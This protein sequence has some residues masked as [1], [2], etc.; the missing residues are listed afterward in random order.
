MLNLLTDSSFMTPSS[1]L[2][3]MTSKWVAMRDVAP[4]VSL[5]KYRFHFFKRLSIEYLHRDCLGPL[6]G[7]Q[8]LVR[9]CATRSGI[10][11]GRVWQ[12]LVQLTSR[13]YCRYLESYLEM[14]IATRSLQASS[15]RRSFF[16]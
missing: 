8:S 16:C 11:N 15:K 2:L 9:K 10:F 3:S 7:I 14:F 13:G 12:V 6:G 5:R 4:R 1:L